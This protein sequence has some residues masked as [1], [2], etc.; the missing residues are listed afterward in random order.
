MLTHT[1][2]DFK[3]FYYQCLFILIQLTKHSEKVYTVEY[4]SNS[5]DWKI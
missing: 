1:D 4:P 5:Q 2:I 3:L